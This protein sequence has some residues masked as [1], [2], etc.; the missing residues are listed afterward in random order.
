MKPWR[1]QGILSPVYDSRLS[2]TR[3]QRNG[4][5]IVPEGQP[6]VIFIVF[7]HPLSSTVVALLPPTRVKGAANKEITAISRPSREKRY[8]EGKLKNLTQNSLGSHKEKHCSSP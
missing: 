6:F 3:F 8:M 4:E 7:L 5:R 1:S 2:T